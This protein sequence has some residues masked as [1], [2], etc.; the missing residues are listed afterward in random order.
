VG[1]SELDRYR[2]EEFESCVV[3]RLLQLHGLGP[4]RR[5]L[6]E[7]SDKE[8][9]G[10]FRL[11][12]VAFHHRFP[13]FPVY[14]L[15]DVVTG[16]A[17]SFKTLT[18]FRNV[19]ETKLFRRYV[20]RQEDQP[21][22]QQHKPFALVFPWPNHV[23]PMILHNG[24]EHSTGP[25]IRWEFPLTETRVNVLM[26]EQLVPLVRALEWSPQDR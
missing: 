26:M 23:E 19:A 15:T 2:R 13:S 16:L 22:D 9:A 5:E 6:M 8:L 12:A 3:Q 14:F 11:S 7:Y 17:S 10:G 21:D 18:I 24:P 25:K 20:G 1:V 4:I